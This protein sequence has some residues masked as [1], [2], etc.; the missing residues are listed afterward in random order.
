[1]RANFS[2]FRVYA[3]RENVENIENM[4]KSGENKKK[5][6]KPRRSKG[7]SFFS[8]SEVLHKIV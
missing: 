4:E 1:M 6:H 2:Y 8:Q 5:S 7:N 3:V